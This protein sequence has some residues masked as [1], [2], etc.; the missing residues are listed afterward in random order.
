MRELA[1]RT[2]VGIILMVIALASALFGGTVFAVLIALIATVMYVEWS[3]MVGQWGIAWRVL[4]FFYCLVPAVA[5]LW[6]RERAE[7][8][9]IGQGFDLLIWV[10]LVVWSTDIGA[11]FAGRAIG[12]PKL[13]PA[14]SPN[15][16][17]AGLIGGVIC[18]ALV[19]GAWVYFVRLPAPLLW[20]S[21]PF[22]V[23]AQLGD[24][25]ESGLKRRA[26]VKDSGTWLPGHGGLLDRLDGLVPVAV[27][28]AA[29]MI[30]G[31]I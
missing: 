26:G 17:I 11:Y 4:G 28:T 22:A 18:A 27:L 13:A 7:Y 16:T 24:L 3:R 15:K 12:G 25:F 14:I 19:A 29:L 20:L 10:F 21:V 23:A 1:T 6:I 2:A 9:G 8:Q 31:A 5:L 30:V